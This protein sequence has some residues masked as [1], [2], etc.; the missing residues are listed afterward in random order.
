[1]TARRAR[2]LWGILLVH[3]LVAAAPSGAAQVAGR[4]QAP[5]ATPE[6]VSTLE[7]T[8][9]TVDVLGNDY[10]PDVDVL[11]VTSATVGAPSTG[12]RVID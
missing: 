8:P 6:N 1:M 7:D 2:L 5:V 10:D 3:T 11:L 9:V 4:G 12:V